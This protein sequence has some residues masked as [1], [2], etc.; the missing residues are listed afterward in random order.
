MP[1]YI[2]DYVWLKTLGNQSEDKDVKFLTSLL[3]EINSLPS[4]KRIYLLHYLAI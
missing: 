4:N 3:G 2:I 1:N